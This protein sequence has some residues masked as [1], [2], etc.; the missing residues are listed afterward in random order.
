MWNHPNNSIR[1]CE[2]RTFTDI[3][4][5]TIAY[6]DSPTRFGYR[7]S[8]TLDIAVINN[9]HFPFTINSSDHNPVFLNFSFLLRI[10]R[11]NH[12]AIT[13]CWS[14]FKNNLNTMVRLEDFAGINNPNV[15][16][17]KI[18]LFT[19]AVRTADQLASK[20][21]ENKK[22]TYTP[23][24]IQELIREKNRAKKLFSQHFKSC[25]QNFIL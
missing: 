5:L 23:N 2:L 9:F 3:L 25:T 16:E 20:P 12:R 19:F 11:Y 21:I 13:T 22:H 17:V 4:D 1:G 6:P 10:H 18:A 7:S 24:R 14:S 8:N 15:L